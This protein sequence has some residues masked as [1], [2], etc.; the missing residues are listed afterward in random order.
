[1]NVQPKNVQ[2][3][4]GLASNVHSTPC[5]VSAAEQRQLP[6]GVEKDVCSS[7]DRGRERGKRETRTAE[8]ERTECIDAL[9]RIE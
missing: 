7:K 5:D 9:Q 1:M 3:S 6:G 8:E 2:S 4:A